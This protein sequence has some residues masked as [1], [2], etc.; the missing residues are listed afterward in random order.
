M[1]QS[2]LTKLKETGEALVKEYLETRNERIKAK[3]VEHYAPLIKNIVGR[4]NLHY[5]TTL[6]ADDLYQFGILGLLKALERFKSNGVPFHAFAYK[7]I[8]GEVVDALRREGMI[9]RDKYEKVRKLETAV[10]NL[11]ASLGR[12]PSTEEVCRALD[13]DEKTYY[14]ILNTSLLVYTTSLNTKISD[15]EGDF[16]YRIDTLT[17]ES[18][19]SP[20]EELENLD[21]KRRLKEIISNE[22][23]DREK[24]ILALYFY[25]ELTLADIRKVINLTEARISQ[26]LN[27]TLIK[28]RVK[29]MK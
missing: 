28:V 12:E 15:D 7:R 9:G 1:M 18:A 17:D 8:Y 5:S 26:I 19:M 22:L 16:I 14:D 2:T 4:Y 11:T 25:E 20:E 13:I 21:L 27:Q 23:S 29:L 10:K 6:S 24:I 3:I